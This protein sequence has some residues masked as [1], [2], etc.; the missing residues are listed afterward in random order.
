MISN[1]NLR[2]II[3]SNGIQVVLTKGH[4]VIDVRCWAIK[5]GNDFVI[6]SL[7]TLISSLM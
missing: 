7:G 5:E 2:H 4:E 1:R 3:I 6:Y